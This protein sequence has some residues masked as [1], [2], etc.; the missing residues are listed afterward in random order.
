M[1][2]VD[3]CI[4]KGMLKKLMIKINELWTPMVLLQLKIRWVVTSNSSLT[5][6]NS[7]LSTVRRVVSKINTITI[8]KE[9]VMEM[10]YIMAQEVDK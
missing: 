10:A 9:V 3:H 8:L 4:K 2:L 5:S 6:I 1:L 7:I